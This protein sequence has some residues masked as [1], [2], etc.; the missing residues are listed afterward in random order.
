MAGHFLRDENLSTFIKRRCLEPPAHPLTALDAL[1][2]TTLEPGLWFGGCG[3]PGHPAVLCWQLGFRGGGLA[4]GV[5][6]L[7]PCMPAFWRCSLLK[8]AL[9]LSASH[10]SGSGPAPFLYPQPKTPDAVFVAPHA[11][12]RRHLHSTSHATAHEAYLCGLGLGV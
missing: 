12:H 7:L 1:V 9:L 3:A 4:A 6:A 2:T 8:V 11:G 10:R 5:W